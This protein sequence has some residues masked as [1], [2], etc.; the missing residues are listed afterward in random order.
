MTD[1][2]ID[3]VFVTNALTIPRAELTY[4]AT[5]SGGAGGQHVNTSSTRIELLWDVENSSAISA[6]ERDRLKTKLASRRTAEGMVRVVASERR[7]QA[8]NRAAAEHRLAELVRRALEVPK[9]RKPTKP[10]R[11]SKEKRL[12]DKKRHSE[13]KKNRRGPLPE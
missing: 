9:K 1:I 2:S 8:Q 4:R 7:S 10:S 11:A 5:R 13:R 3:G 12:T 6:D